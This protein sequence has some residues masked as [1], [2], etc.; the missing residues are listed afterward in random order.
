MKH[1]RT[2]FV[3]VICAI[4]FS[5]CDGREGF[6]SVSDPDRSGNKTCNGI[7]V[8][9]ND[10]WEASG[11]DVIPFSGGQRVNYH[12]TGIVTEK[13]VLRVTGGE[14]I[15][16]YDQYGNDYDVRRAAPFEF[17]GKEILGSGM[18][19]KKDRDKSKGIK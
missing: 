7:I 19:F 6:Y 13:G 9:G 10:T 17:D 1:I 12:Y 15:V 18:R 11:T 16:I 4:V 3:I 2:F 5:S 14:N 8:Y